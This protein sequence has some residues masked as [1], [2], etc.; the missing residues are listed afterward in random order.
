[1][2]LSNHLKVFQENVA[3]KIVMDWK[4]SVAQMLIESA[5][6]F[7]H[8]VMIAVNLQIV[9]WPAVNVFKWIVLDLIGAR[10]V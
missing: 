1:M 5:P 10:L 6:P 4:L 2:R 8:R 3:L 9:R 7:M